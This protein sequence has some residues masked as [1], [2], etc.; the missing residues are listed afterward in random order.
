MQACVG[1][2]R[3]ALRRSS[4][5]APSAVSPCWWERV[6][7]VK[8]H[9]DKDGL[10]GVE[11]GAPPAPSTTFYAPAAGESL[12]ADCPNGSDLARTASAVYSIGV[13]IWQNVVVILVAGGS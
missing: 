9:I 5:P 2:G 3:L 6:P 1:V 10:D 13:A 11:W 4:P 7:M 8:G 12:T